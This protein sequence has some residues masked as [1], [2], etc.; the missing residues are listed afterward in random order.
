MEIVVEQAGVVRALGDLTTKEQNSAGGKGGI[1][2]RLYQSGYPVPDG[3]VILPEAFVVDALKAEARRQVQA[4]LARMRKAGD[5]FSCA[6][7]SSALSEDSAQAS[8]A[9]EFETVLGVQS[10]DAVRA[11]VE[12]VRRSRH[13]ERVRVY[14]G[15]HGLETTQEMAVIVQKMVPAELSGVLFTADPVT[16]SRTAM[17]GNFVPGLGDKLVSGEV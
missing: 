16:G 8:F 11:A 15:A 5:V 3:F 7:R 4:H 1:L 17:T 14:G 10:D 2:A 9:G 13:A 12:A 6:V